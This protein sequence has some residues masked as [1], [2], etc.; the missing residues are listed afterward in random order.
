M[1]VSGGNYISPRIAIVMGGL[2]FLL[3]F[4]HIPQTFALSLEEEAKREGKV[5]LYFGMVVPDIQAIADAFQK[6]YPS[7]KVEYYRAGGSKLLQKI[8]VEKE[9]GKSFADVLAPIGGLVGVYK[10]KGLLTRYVSPESQIYPE[11]F[12]DPEGFWTAYYTTYKLFIYNTKMVAGK[13]A[14]KIYED[15]LDP[16]W[17]GKIGISNDEF[18]W[19]IGML[20]FMGE[21]RGRRFMKRLGDQN[22]RISSGL[23]LASQLLV[24]GEFPIALSNSKR[25]IALKKAGAPVECIAS[26]NPTIATPRCVGISANAAHPNAARLMVD[27]ILSREGQNVL[28]R[29]D[30]DPIRP[31]I[32]RDPDTEAL[33]LKVFP[34]KPKP[35]ELLESLMKEYRNILVK[36]NVR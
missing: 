17:N 25:G 4:F 7:I 14:P 3:V 20:D 22:P 11:G 23:T 15:L 24:A 1:R 27:F 26:L 8:L 12:K 16:K 5:I 32:R 31:D 36:R 29:I 13:E 34:A 28:N 35:P 10:Q 9:L 2:V 33:N 19:Y 21:E 30:R 6:K 18:E